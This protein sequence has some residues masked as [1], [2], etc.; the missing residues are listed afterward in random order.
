MAFS[1]DGRLMISGSDDKTMRI[2]DIVTGAERQVLKG[3]SAPVAAVDFSPDGRL[4]ISGSMDGEV[5][6]WD[7]VAGTMQ[8]A[9][10]GHLDRVD[11]VAFSPNNQFIVSAARRGDTIQIWDAITGV[12]QHKLE[13]HSS[14]SGT[15]SFSPDSRLI[16]SHFLDGSIRIWDVMTGAERHVFYTGSGLMHL[17][18]SSCGKHLVTERGVLPLF[19][20]DCQCANHIF[21]NNFWMKLDGKD[22]LYLNPDYFFSFLSS[23]KVVYTG[24]PSG[25]L[26]FDMSKRDH[27]PT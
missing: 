2:W 15:I 18:F 14:R 23:N 8:R 12:K 3:H 26:Q 27:S 17:S 25:V 5:R 10:E 11:A 7:T 9:L 21:A 19:P 13:C 4:I 1:P 24:S 16:V 6:I 20:L 22:L